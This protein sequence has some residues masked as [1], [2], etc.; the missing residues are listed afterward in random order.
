MSRGRRVAPKPAEEPST[1][2]ER[3]RER[4]FQAA[5]SEFSAKGFEGASMREIARRAEV[6]PGLLYRYF[7]AKEDVVR[8][9]YA[10]LSAQ[11]AERGKALPAG[12]WT[13]RAIWLTRNSL[14][15]L[16]G[17]RDVLRSML[18]TILSGLDE[19][20][21]PDNAYSRA[22]VQPL[23]AQAVQGAVDAPAEAGELAHALY[24]G[25]LM[26]LLFWL[27]DRT[28]KQRA[29]QELLASVELSAPLIG[30]ALAMP[31]VR[32]GLDQFT[33]TVRKGLLG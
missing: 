1:K 12:T 16:Q 25:H 2:G 9:L 23:F 6:S 24:L 22:H 31:M 20:N 29:T 19:L 4:L 27:V 21:P 33:A 32:A 8:E 10:R 3:T 7:D 18:G 30:G 26:L 14:E 17:H 15:V 5:I 11:W 13:Q 28:P